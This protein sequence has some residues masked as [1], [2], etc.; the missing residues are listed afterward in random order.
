VLEQR[1]VED[2][3]LLRARVDEALAG[4]LRRGG[5]RVTTRP[6]GAARPRRA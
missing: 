2:R 6:N 4:R 1:V 5:A 3:L